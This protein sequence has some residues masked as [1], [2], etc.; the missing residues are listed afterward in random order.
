M[1]ADPILLLA[2][3]V[4]FS[5]NAALVVALILLKV[6]HRRKTT[7]HDVRRQRYL[8]TLSC[9]VSIENCDQPITKAMAEDQAFL[10]ALIDMRNAITGDDLKALRDIVRT[11]GII[12]RQVKRL[13]SPFPLGRRLRAAVALAELGD[14]SAADA[15]VLH[16]E[17][18]EP[19]I[20]IQCARGLG[21]IRWT[22]AI[23]HILWRF[24]VESPWVQARFSDVLAG[25]GS[26]ATWPLLAFVRINHSFDPD[27]TALA[28]HTL[29]QVQDDQA[30]APLLEI[31]GEATDVEVEMA[32]VDA[33]G[34]L[35]SSEATPAIVERLE[36]AHPDLR[37]KAARALGGVRDPAAIPLLTMSMRDPNW[38][39]RRASAAAISRLPG[40]VSALLGLLEDDDPFAA[41]AAA[42]ALTDI[43]ELVPERLLNPAGSEEGSRAG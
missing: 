14:E 41:D 43:G 36:S 38:S 29:G 16:L 37:A 7:T 10:D 30:V 27:G 4:I 2:V 33:L 32:A 11:H 23:D 39:V 26:S 18:R 24:R 5:I 25:F 22:P 34:S 20:R 1:Q 19:E 13:D 17:D 9:H 40:G 12:E 21:R 6:T 3:L 8:Q 15:L 42:E 28:L 31:L 35:G